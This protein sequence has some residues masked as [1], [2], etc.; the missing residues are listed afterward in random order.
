MLDLLLN[1][2]I[3][4]VYGKVREVKE[5]GGSVFVRCPFIK[6]SQGLGGKVIGKVILAGR[7]ARVT[8][9]PGRLRHVGEAG[10]TFLIPSLAPVEV[11]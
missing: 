7:I 1:A 4:S 9:G 2:L 11:G 10:F 3:G 5:E 8:D 6:V